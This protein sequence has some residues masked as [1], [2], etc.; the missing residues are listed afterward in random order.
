MSEVEL[1]WVQSCDVCGCEHRHMENH[2]IESQDQAESE[3]GAFWERCNS[4]YRAHVEAVQA[5]QSLYAMHA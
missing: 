3:T 2:P 1:V 4:W 5:Q